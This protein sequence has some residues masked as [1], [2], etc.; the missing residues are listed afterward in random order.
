MEVPN[1]QV[2]KSMQSLTS[3]G[4]VKTQFAWQH[5]YYT[6]TNEGIEYLKE[7][8]H[9]PSEI[10]PAMFKKIA[11]PMDVHLK[12]HEGAYCIG[13]SEGYRRKEGGA[14]GPKLK[15]GMYRS[16]KIV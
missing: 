16:L 9:L 8:L 4:Y 7:Y 14:G 13:G 6:L 10:V 1:L 11:K 12:G 3:R 2:I 15:I 5:Y